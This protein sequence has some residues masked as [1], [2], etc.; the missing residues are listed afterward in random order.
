[1][2]KDLRIGAR[3]LTAA[4]L[5]LSLQAG[6]SFA[7]TPSQLWARQLGTASSDLAQ[8][9]ALD[10]AGNAYISGYTYGA[11]G[12]A[13][14]GDADAFLAK[15]DVAGNLLW[16]RQLGSATRDFNHS[17]AVDAAGNA[18]ISGATQG[19]L[20]GTNLGQYDAFLTKYDASGNLVWTRQTGSTQTDR[21]VGV[22]LDS[23]GNAYLTG[24]T[25]GDVGAPNAGLGDMFLT[26]Y[27]AA[28][29]HVWDRQLGSPTWDYGESVTVDGS[30]NIFV[31]GYTEGVLGASNAGYRDAYLT[32]YNSSGTL[33]WTEQ[34]GTF[35]ADYSTSVAVDAGGN[36]FITGH[37]QAS[38]GGPSAGDIDVFLAKYD[39]A[40]NQLWV[41]QIG[42]VTYEES[43]SVA[44]DSAGNAYITGHALYDLAGPRLGAID[45]FVIKFDASGN[46]EW[47]EQVGTAADD[48]GR[49]I[50]V[51]GSDNVYITGYTADALGGPHQGGYDAFLIKF[52][53]EPGSL[54]LLGLGGLLVVKRRRRNR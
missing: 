41:E 35:S 36:A 32:K 29:N 42:T 49:G 28:G 6:V 13:H 34:L 12:G 52:V 48:F 19:A 30:G 43:H 38:L 14:Q 5:A 25:T 27:D 22:A 40:G 53:P 7:L 51:D 37:T 11:L 23:A 47:S 18:Y 2:F 9:V 39:G 44:V 26:K 50:A 33:Q 20:D 15:Y 17:V 31:T 10:S 4:A 1:M 21:S 45:A 16:T 54:A 8:S 3:F 24:Y 46:L